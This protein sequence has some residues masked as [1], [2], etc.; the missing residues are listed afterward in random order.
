MNHIYSSNNSIP[1]VYVV[2]EI[3]N[4]NPFFEVNQKIS[5]FNIIGVY[6]D[7]YLAQVEC[8]KNFRRHMLSSEFHRSIY[9][10]PIY[11]TDIEKPDIPQLLSPQP[12]KPFIFLGTMKSNSPHALNIPERSSN[13]ELNISNPK[14]N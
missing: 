2:V 3:N 12:E 9:P 7:K 10:D 8:S 6:E 1:I 13:P 4:D 14:I 11:C 5:Y